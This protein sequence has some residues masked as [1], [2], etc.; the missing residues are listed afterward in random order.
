[1]CYLPVTILRVFSGNLNVKI[2]EFLIFVTQLIQI[3]SGILDGNYYEIP[4][5]KISGTIISVGHTVHS[6]PS[7]EPIHFVF[8]LKL[9]QFLTQRENV[10]L[11]KVI[12]TMIIDSSKSQREEKLKH[13]QVMI[14][15]SFFL[16]K[17][18]TDQAP[19]MNS[20]PCMSP[21]EAFLCFSLQ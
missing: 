7:G 21:E 19:I 3:V 16:R 17:E 8:I 4:R 20:N 11:A 12:N 10:H 14:S 18:I 13:A 6:N 9:N 15:I 2:I 5:K 1:M